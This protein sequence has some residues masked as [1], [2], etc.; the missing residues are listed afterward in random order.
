ML[1]KAKTMLAKKGSSV[2]R[3]DLNQSLRVGSSLRKPIGSLKTSKSTHKRNATK[4][5]K[6][7]SK[8]RYDLP[9]TK[10]KKPKTL[11]KKDYIHGNP[12]KGEYPLKTKTLK[13]A[14]GKPAKKDDLLRS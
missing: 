4:T 8:S 2:R 13:T 12:G 10:L 3:N 6:S 14:R 7:K 1:S 5:R 11:R 9:Q